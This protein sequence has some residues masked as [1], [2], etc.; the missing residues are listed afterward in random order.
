MM[1]EL[2]FEINH[3]L[4]NKIYLPYIEDDDKRKT[5]LQI[6]FG[7]ASSGKSFYI[8]QRIVLDTL[9]GR[10]TL[11]LRNV[12][13]TLRGSCWNEVTKAITR[14]RLMDEFDISKTE[15]LVTSSRCGSQI[16]FAGLDDVEKIKLPKPMPISLCFVA[17]ISWAK[18]LKFFRHKKKYWCPTLKPAARWPTAV[19]PTH[20]KHLQRLTLIILCIS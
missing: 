11:V 8:A 12:A 1:S 16:L 9:A 20:L 3:K 19:L 4:F 14:M 5:R 2:T 13:R 10:N 18:Q 7:G 15:M 17:F 6:F